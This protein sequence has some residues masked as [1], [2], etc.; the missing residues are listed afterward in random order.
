MK[1]PYWVF[2]NLETRQALVR[3]N[4]SFDEIETLKAHGFE[5]IWDSAPDAARGFDYAEEFGGRTIAGDPQDCGFYRHRCNGCGL[6]APVTLRTGTRWHEYH[7]RNILFQGYVCD[8]CAGD[9]VI[10]TLKPLVK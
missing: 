1:K 7:Q 4:P 5:L 8:G 3:A 9:Q 6:Y 2:G 10:F